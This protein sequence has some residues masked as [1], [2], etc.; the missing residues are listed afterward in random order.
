M[1]EIDQRIAISRACSLVAPLSIRTHW[2][3]GVNL[4]LW[5]AS[6]SMA[7]AQAAGGIKQ[8][9]AHYVKPRVLCIDELGY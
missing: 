4:A 9:L 7:A 1:R 5:T 2:F 6:T 8:A 3:R